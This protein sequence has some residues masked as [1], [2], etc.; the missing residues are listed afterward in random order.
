MWFESC[1]V[2]AENIN[3]LRWREHRFGLTQERWKTLCGK[4]FWITGAGTGYGRAMACALA[5]A[6]A[7]VFLTGRRL[8]KLKETIK[9]LEDTFGVDGA[10]CYPLRADI[11]DEADIKR[12]VET[13]V[14][15][16]NTLYGLINNA[17]LPSKPG[18]RFPLMDDPVEYWDKIMSTNVRA[19]WLI[20]K[21]VFPHM[22]KGGHVRVLF[23]TSEAGWAGTPGFG[24]YNVSKAALNNLAYSMAEEYAARYPDIDIQMNVLSPGEA[25]TEMNQGSNITPY[26]IVSMALILL[27]HPP[28]GPNGKFFHRDG[29]ALEFCYSRPYTK[30]LL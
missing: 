4:A 17:A 19:P 20:T 6:G 11:T 12:A 28:E 10:N 5:M 23:I 2:I 1:R 13:I 29:R 30:S 25:R 15:N 9:E 22:L 8:E 21:T 24:M 3:P 18:S 27:S 16:C 26:A 7:K 14:E